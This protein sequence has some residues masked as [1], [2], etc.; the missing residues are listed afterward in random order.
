VDDIYGGDTDDALN[1]YD[2]TDG[3]DTDLD[4]VAFRVV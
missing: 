2:L 3:M 4:A 1:S